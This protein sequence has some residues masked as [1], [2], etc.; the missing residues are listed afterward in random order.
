MQRH[1]IWHKDISF[2][3]HGY[4]TSIKNT[5]ILRLKGCVQHGGGVH[6]GTA[7]TA[8]NIVT[9]NNFD[10]RTYLTDA[11]PGQRWVIEPLPEDILFSHEYRFHIPKSNDRA[12]GNED[13]SMTPSFDMWTFPHG[14]LPP[15]WSLRRSASLTRLVIFEPQSIVFNWQRGHSELVIARDEV[16]VLSGAPGINCERAYLIPPHNHQWFREQEMQQYCSG[17]R[18]KHGDTT[19]HDAANGITLRADLRRAFDEGEWV[20]VPKNGD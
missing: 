2:H 19:L 16:C 1:A 17:S 11:P 4:N 12:V 6:A 5:V 3:H 8:L 9:G 10:K 14:R 15:A 7:M 20:I 18:K 13:Y